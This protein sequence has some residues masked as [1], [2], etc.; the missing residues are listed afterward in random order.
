MNYFR[1]PS[2]TP[3]AGGPFPTIGT[4][5][6]PGMN[7]GGRVGLGV[8]G[9]PMDMADIIKLLELDMSLGGGSNIGSAAGSGDVMRDAGFKTIME[10]LSE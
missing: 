2:S 5:L 7:Q 9:D 4:S 8:G 1:R 6:V 3:G 10:L